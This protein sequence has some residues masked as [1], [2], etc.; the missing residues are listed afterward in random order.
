MELF[1]TLEYTLC[2][3]TSTGTVLDTSVT[4]LYF[5][6]R[7]SLDG[8]TRKMLYIAAISLRLLPFKRQGRFTSYGKHKVG[9]SSTQ[10]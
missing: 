6:S 10:R 5:Q 3:I 4:A 7:T 2:D 8:L 1:R 9:N